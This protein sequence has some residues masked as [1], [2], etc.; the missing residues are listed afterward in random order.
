MKEDPMVTLARAYHFAATRY[1]N[2]RRKGEA[3]E[4]HMNHLTEVAELVAIARPTRRFVDPPQGGR[5]PSGQSFRDLAE[6]DARHCQ[7]NEIRL[8]SLV[9]RLGNSRSPRVSH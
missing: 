3:A 9:L 8:R 4:R 6:G 1:V 2:Q 7:T 5:A